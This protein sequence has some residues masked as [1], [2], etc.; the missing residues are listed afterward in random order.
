MARGVHKLMVQGGVIRFRA[1]KAWRARHMQGIR[2]GLVKGPLMALNDRGPVGHAAHE[3]YAPLDGGEAGRGHPDLRDRHAIKLRGVEDG[4]IPEDE[5]L[6]LVPAFWVFCGVYLPEDDR[7]A[8]LAFAD[9]APGRFHLVEG[10]P[11]RGGVAHGRQQ[12]DVHAS[13]G[14]LAEEVTRQPRHA[15]P[16]L[17]PRYRALL[18]Q[19]ENPVGYDLVRFVDLC[20]RHGR[21]LHAR[22][23]LKNGVAREFMAPERLFFI[24]R[25]TAPGR[26]TRH[27]PRPGG[28]TRC[29]G[30]CARAASRLRGGDTTR[31]PGDWG[32]AWPA[33]G[34]S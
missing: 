15:V 28:C 26:C 13:V 14:P 31:S 30:R 8:A 10:R 3:L 1:V 21:N 24:A 16:G 18:Q 23:W 11:A 4:E 29:P 12:P 33:R 22:G 19:R 17:M 6:V 2:G 27:R 7:D 9:A 25:R 34:L 32:R 20:Y 5:A